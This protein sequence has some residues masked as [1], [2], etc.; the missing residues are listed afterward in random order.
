[1]PH[2]V[3]IKVFTRHIFFQIKVILMQVS[4]TTKQRLKLRLVRI[5]FLLHPENRKSTHMVVD[6]VS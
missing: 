3:K 5:M 4:A 6:N 2:D 1:M